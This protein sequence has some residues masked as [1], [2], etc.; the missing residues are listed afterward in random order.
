[1]GAHAPLVCVDVVLPIGQLL[2]SLV[3]PSEISEIQVL[4]S[5]R[6]RFAVSNQ[7]DVKVNYYVASRSNTIP[8]GLALMCRLL[9]KG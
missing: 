9:L 3:P 8:D 1:M 5:K 4:Q 6:V 2:G 7:H